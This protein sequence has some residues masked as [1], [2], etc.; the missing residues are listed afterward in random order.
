M[1]TIM[2][3]SHNC[4]NRLMMTIV[5]IQLLL[6]SEQS[7]SIVVQ[8]LSLAI[9]A[10]L[11]ALYSYKLHLQ[12]CCKIVTMSLMVHSPHEQYHHLVENGRAADCFGD[13]Q[14]Q[15]SQHRQPPV[16]SL[17]AGCERTEAA[18]IG[19][20]AIHDGHDRCICEQLHRSHE[21]HQSAGA[22]VE[23]LLRH[24]QPC[25]LLRH[26]CPHHAQHG[27]AAVDHL[28]GRTV[29]R[30]D[31]E[32]RLVA[33]LG[34]PLDLGAGSEAHGLVEACGGLGAEVRS[35]LGLVGLLVLQNLGFGDLL[36]GALVNNLP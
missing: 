2:N 23:Q 35:L 28:R 3:S 20:L 34:T 17:R 27:Q 8:P 10:S 12:N 11:H 21:V 36:L 31:A 4:N 26:E 1:V 29:E 18:S 5:M 32:E 30:E 22:G 33:G 24:A 13:D 19:G 14:R 7:T 6:N 16:P 25:H 15:E 9:Q